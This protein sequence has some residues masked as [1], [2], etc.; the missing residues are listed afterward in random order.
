MLYFI[1]FVYSR[2]R[3]TEENELWEYPKQL[4]QF[5]APGYWRLRKRD[6]R[7]EPNLKDI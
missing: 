5:I 7:L 6:K 2:R 1:Y 3:H 4:L